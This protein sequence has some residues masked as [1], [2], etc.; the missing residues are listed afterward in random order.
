MFAFGEIGGEKS[1]VALVSLEAL[2]ALLLFVLLLIFCHS[3]CDV[4]FVLRFTDACCHLSRK[5]TRAICKCI[6]LEWHFCQRFSWPLRL[7]I[8]LGFSFRCRLFSAKLLKFISVPWFSRWFIAKDS[9]LHQPH[10]RSIPPFCANGYAIVI[11]ANSAKLELIVF[12]CVCVCMFE[13]SAEMLCKAQQHHLWKEPEKDEKKPETGNHSLSTVEVMWSSNEIKPNWMYSRHS[14]S[15]LYTSILLAR[16][17]IES[18]R[19][20]QWKEIPPKRNTSSR[21]STKNSSNSDRFQSILSPDTLQYWE[22]DTCTILWPNRWFFCIY[23]YLSTVPPHWHWYTRHSMHTNER[24][25]PMSSVS[26]PSPNIITEIIS[27]DLSMRLN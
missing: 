24:I 19:S 8:V 4:V 12:G 16:N 23:I 2:Q 14:N 11:C 7:V 10:T 20:A 1:C 27:H 6:L 25:V 3:L 21:M 13:C 18:M 22:N 9:V 17:L 5:N 26:H 15:T